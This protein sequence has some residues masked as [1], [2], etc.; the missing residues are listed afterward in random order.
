MPTDLDTQPRDGTSPWTGPLPTLGDVY[1][2]RKV[3]AR[4]L[5]PTPLLDAEKLSERLGVTT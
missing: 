2:A 4:Y 5:A 3:I 1:R